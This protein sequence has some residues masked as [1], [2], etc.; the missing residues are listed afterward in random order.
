MKN[1]NRAIYIGSGLDTRPLFLK[2]QKRIKYFYYID[3]YPQIYHK[4]VFT[5]PEPNLYLK[6]MEQLDLAFVSCG[7]NLKHCSHYIRIYKEKKAFVNRYVIYFTN[8]KYPLDFVKIQSYIPYFNIIICTKFKPNIC[9]YTHLYTKNLEKMLCNKKFRKTSLVLFEKNEYLI[10]TGDNDSLI[11]HLHYNKAMRT[12]FKFYH[13]SYAN[14]RLVLTKFDS[15]KRMMD[16]HIKNSNFFENQKMNK[17]LI[18]NNNEHLLNFSN[19]D[20]KNTDP[21]VNVDCS[22]LLLE[23]SECSQSSHSGSTTPLTN[24]DRNHSGV[25]FVW[26]K[27]DPLV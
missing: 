21:Y 12:Q 18:L 7:F 17:F 19:L 4:D 5:K 11:Y 16:H 9:F 15:W 10:G 23:N 22:T 13:V 24:L 26:D 2:L 14:S 6:L 25:M 1:C 27:D 3:I 8:I 20:K